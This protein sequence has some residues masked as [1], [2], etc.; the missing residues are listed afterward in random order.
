MIYTAGMEVPVNKRKND[1]QNSQDESS[2]PENEPRE[3]LIVQRQ[4]FDAARQRA[5]N[6]LPPAY[7]F[8]NPRDYETH[9]QMRMCQ[10]TAMS[11]CNVTFFGDKP[12]TVDQLAQGYVDM[13]SGTR[14]QSRLID[15]LQDQVDSLTELIREAGPG[16]GN[17]S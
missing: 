10:E 15:D 17:K 14:K 8:G 13:E 12:G 5:I 1:A 7:T 2:E 3:F 9:I 16:R 11:F 6:T 4:Y